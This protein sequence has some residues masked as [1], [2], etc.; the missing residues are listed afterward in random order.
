MRMMGF[1]VIWKA[2]QNLDQAMK[3]GQ[4]NPDEFWSYLAENPNA[5][6]IFNKCDESKGGRPSR[7]DSGGLRFFTP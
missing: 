1:P 2:A 5:S 3:T 6:R 4:V 7:G